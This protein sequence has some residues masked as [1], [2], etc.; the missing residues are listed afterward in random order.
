ML[1]TNSK[2]K[3]VALVT[4]NKWKNKVSEDIRLRYYL[5][6]IHVKADI[7][8]WEEKIHIRTLGSLLL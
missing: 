5:A 2:N 1:F 6:K 4:C 3:R 8:A 7:I